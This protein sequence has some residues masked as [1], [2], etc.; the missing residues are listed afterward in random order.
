MPVLGRMRGWVAGTWRSMCAVELLVP[1]LQCSS[2]AAG[3]LS[4][5]VLLLISA[6]TRALMMVVI[7]DGRDSKSE[8]VHSGRIAGL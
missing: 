4:R 5:S 3:Y 8:L 6:A 7:C 1:S 2:S